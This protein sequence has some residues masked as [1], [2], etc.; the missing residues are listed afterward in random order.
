[1]PKTFA[2]KI[3]LSTYK[4]VS[5]RHQPDTIE[6]LPFDQASDSTKTNDLI[7]SFC[8]STDM[9]ATEIKTIA[10]EKLLSSRG[11]LYLV[12]PKLKNKLGLPG[13]H[14]DV[15][16]PALHVDADSGAVADTGLKFSRMVSFDDNYTAVGLT[17]LASNPRRADNPSG[18]VATYEDRLS[19]LKQLINADNDAHQ[20]FDTLTPGY[21]RSWAR[22]VFSPKTSV[23]QQA[24][25]QQMIT[26]L[27]E[28]YASVELWHQGKKRH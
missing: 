20:A 7:L 15:L 25:L 19:E 2:D 14:R 24:H 22:Y 18:R 3:K 8:L 9:M 27:K 16:F 5:I 17:W 26:L 1:M 6:S 13:I 21:Q 10:D 23:T 12:Y 4:H 28:D 11:Y